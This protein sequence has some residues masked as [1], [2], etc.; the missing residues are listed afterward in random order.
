MW[1]RPKG[2]GINGVGAP[3]YAVVFWPHS[4]KAFR[5]MPNFAKNY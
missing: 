1:V 4:G 5:E 2:N 3:V